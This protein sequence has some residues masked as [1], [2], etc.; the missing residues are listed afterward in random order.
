[1]FAERNQTIMRKVF[2]ERV[3]RAARLLASSQARHR[4]IT[5]IAFAC[6]L[7]DS[8]HFTRAF[9]ARMAMTPSRWRKQ[10]AGD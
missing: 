8:A 2:D 10:M 3:E 9:A 6:G 4:L 1:V 7:N 5:E